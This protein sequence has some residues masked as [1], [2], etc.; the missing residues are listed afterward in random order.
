MTVQFAKLHISPTFALPRTIPRVSELTARLAP[1]VHKVWR[2]LELIG[3]ARA[4]RELQRL[5]VRYAHNPKFA[6]SLRDAMQLGSQG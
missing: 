5:S 2:E 4:E 3:Q 1:I 6:R